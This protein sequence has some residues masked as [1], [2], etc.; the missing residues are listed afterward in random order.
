[1]A[2]LQQWQQAGGVSVELAEPA[3]AS[4][5]L[6]AEQVGPPR[7]PPLRPSGRHR[8]AAHVVLRTDPR[9][10]P[11]GHLRQQRARGGRHRRRA[12]RR[13]G[14][15]CA[16]A[17]GGRLLGSG[18]RPAFTDGGAAGGPHLRLARPRGPRARRPAGPRPACRA[19]DARRRRPSGG[20][21]STRPPSDL[22]EA[23]LPMQHTSLG[24]LA[25]GAPAG[26]PRPA[27]PALRARLRVPA[28]PEGRRPARE[29]ALAAM[30]GVLRRHLSADD[31]MRAYADRLEAPGLGDQ[32]L[33]GYLSGSIDVVLRVGAPGQQRYLVV[34]YKTNRL[35]TPGEPLTALDYTPE[36]MTEAML[37]SHYPLQAL[38][39]S[40]VLHR[41]LRWRQPGYDP[42]RHLGGILYLYLR[43]M[44][45]PETPEVDGQP[46][47]VFAWR[48]PAAHG[49]RALRPV[50]RL[51][52]RRGRV[53]SVR[54]PRPR[55][56]GGSPSVRPACC[57]SSTRPRCSARPTSTSPP[58]S[59]PS[60]RSR[61][62]RCSWPRR[63]PSAPS[64]TARS[65]STCRR[66]PTSPST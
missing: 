28:R 32:L 53:V 41:Y 33:R 43:G 60:S 12:D 18:R 30:A 40:V 35:G 34:D 16:G 9:R 5:R 64:G 36:R 17:A 1:M 37:H 8:L 63:S 59:A 23:L 61:A 49:R 50:G 31:P 3:A 55:T 24:P 52:H 45:G 11:R 38:L 20:G 2:Q 65:A 51:R 10:G 25:D 19:R 39:Y 15:R 66:S 57:A 44:C 42:D 48:P 14:R 29:V 21:R 46:C 58:G 56:P 4:V 7:H 54:D 6:E 47:G 13:R 26:R 22:A 27:R 62:R